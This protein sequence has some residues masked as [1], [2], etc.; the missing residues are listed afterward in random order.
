M[1]A[2]GATLSKLSDNHQKPFVVLQ[3]CAAY[4]EHKS[5]CTSMTASA[6]KPQLRHA[7]LSKLNSKRSGKQ[8]ALQKGFTLVELMIV[9]VIVGI[10]SAIALPSFMSQS[11]KAKLTEA[12]Q[13]SSA[14]L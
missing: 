4:G 3:I 6:L 10:L 12:K 14:Y 2:V 1:Q 13:Q 7:L 5:P 9:I 8:N 11:D